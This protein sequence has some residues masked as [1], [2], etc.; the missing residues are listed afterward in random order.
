VFGPRPIAV[1]YHWDGIGRVRGDVVNDL[2]PLVGDADVH[3]PETKVA[4]R[5]VVP[6]CRRRRIAA[7]GLALDR[8][9]EGAGVVQRRDRPGVG[10]RTA[11]PPEDDDA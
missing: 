2:F 9:A 10:P 6:S 8:R 11:E 1:P 3:I 5:D 4:S 7:T